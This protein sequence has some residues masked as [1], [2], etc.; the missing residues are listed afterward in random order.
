MKSLETC[1][2]DI[3]D[4]DEDK[5]DNE[6]MEDM[7]I[8]LTLSKLH[9]FYLN[10]HDKDPF[11]SLKKSS[12]QMIRLNAIKVSWANIRHIF[13]PRARRALRVYF[14]ALLFLFL[15]LFFLLLG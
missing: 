7:S 6:E 12:D 4:E 8:I 13:Y 14:F 9:P 11:R 10:N 3:E 1:F 2:E 15:F 5:S